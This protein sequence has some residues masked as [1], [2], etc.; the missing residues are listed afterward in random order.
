MLNAPTALTH[1]IGHLNAAPDGR[2]A[3]LYPRLVCGVILTDF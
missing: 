2:R 3:G 1:L